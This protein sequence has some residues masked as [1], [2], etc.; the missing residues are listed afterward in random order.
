M[1]RRK[2]RKLP[3]WDYLMTFG[4]SLDLY[5]QSD[6][7]MAVDRDNG[8]IALRYSINEK[9]PDYFFQARKNNAGVKSG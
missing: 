4:D 6:K 3:G 5:G 1:I 2:I 9:D 7:R 8:R